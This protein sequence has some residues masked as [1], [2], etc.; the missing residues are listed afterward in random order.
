MTREKEPDWARITKLVY[1][2]L[3]RKYHW[4][5]E[6]ELLSAAGLGVAEADARYAPRNPDSSR[7]AWLYLK[8]YYLALD[9]LRARGVTFRANRKPRPD[10]LQGSAI[11]NSDGTEVPF[12]AN[13]CVG[14]PQECRFPTS[15]REW[16]RGLSPRERKILV[17]HYDEGMTYKNIGKIFDRSE[18]RICQIATVAIQKLRRMR[19][20]EYAR[21]ERSRP[22]L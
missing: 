20:I 4:V 11:T 16:L 19:A 21:G 3:R 18:A 12:A 13:E 17:L 2:R 10:V 9:G 15:C 22:W 6:D 1:C 5:E 14:V 8:G 7:G